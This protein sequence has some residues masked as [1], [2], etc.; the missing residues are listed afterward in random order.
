MG[1]GGSGGWTDHCLNSDGSKYCWDSG[2]DTLGVNSG[3]VLCDTLGGNGGGGLDG[4]RIQ[5]NL[6]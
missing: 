1:Y 4:D 2:C 5:M 3:G 6:T